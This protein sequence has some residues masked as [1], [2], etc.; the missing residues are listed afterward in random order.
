M[1]I[2]V[3]WTNALVG[4]T[5]VIAPRHTAHRHTI[6]W[7]FEIA[8]QQS[9]QTH[10]TSHCKYPMKGI[11]YVHVTNSLMHFS[12]WIIVLTH[13]NWCEQPTLVHSVHDH[14]QRKLWKIRFKKTEIRSAINVL[15]TFSTTTK[16]KW[17]IINW[18][19]HKSKWLV[20][21][22]FT[23][24]LTSSIADM[25]CSDCV[26]TAALDGSKMRENAMR[27]KITAKCSFLCDCVSQCQ[28]R[29]AF[30]IFRLQPLSVSLL[31]CSKHD[32]ALQPLYSLHPV[33]TQWIISLV[34]NCKIQFENERN[35]GEARSQWLYVRIAN[36]DYYLSYVLVKLNWVCA[37]CARAPCAA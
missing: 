6:L 37:V 13:A 5:C 29:T 32:S 1:Q 31:I 19:S 34:S 4:S 24:F 7:N 14:K 20:R 25:V 21:F 30:Y 11:S 12:N 28:I 3:L 18:N 9:T 36:C 10:S 27:R 35:L 26:H 16:L 8:C 33:T 2:R 23:N 22:L 15:W 17:K